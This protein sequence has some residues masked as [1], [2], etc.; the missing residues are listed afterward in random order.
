V[1]AELE[2]LRGDA[3][4]ALPELLV[5][6]ANV[7]S[8]AWWPRGGGGDLDRPRVAGSPRPRLPEPGDPD[9][10]AAYRRMTQELAR[11]HA[12]LL[13][14]PPAAWQPSRVLF[15]DDRQLRIL[16]PDL[17]RD[18]PLP[19]LRAAVGVL[20]AKLRYVHLRPLHPEYVRGAA[21]SAVA[22]Y[23]AFPVDVRR[24]PAAGDPYLA[25]E[26][27]CGRPAGRR[28]RR[29]SQTCANRAS[30]YRRKAAA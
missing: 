21:A 8:V 5:V 22:A 20:A 2:R 15:A 11:A 3:L 12:W 6:A 26:C 13:G 14:V 23:E 27:G 19:E 10:V 30:R 29:L 1:D 7:R 24:P 9:L 28:G 25:C 16:P 18:V 4:A 17:V